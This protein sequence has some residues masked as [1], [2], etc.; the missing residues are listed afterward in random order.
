MKPNRSIRYNRWIF[1]CWLASVVTCSA[2][3]PFE[4]PEG[5][6]DLGLF[7]A[8]LCLAILFTNM[9]VLRTYWFGGKHSDPPI[10][11]PPRWRI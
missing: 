1:Y 3:L 2:S 6:H 11:D 7:E 5:H 10:E 8:S 4:G 9:G